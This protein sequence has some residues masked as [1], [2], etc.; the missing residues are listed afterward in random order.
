MDWMRRTF[1][2][3]LHDGCE[4]GASP[5]KV[6]GQRRETA[7]KRRL[8]VAA[9]LGF[10]ALVAA[11][12]QAASPPPTPP[13]DPL[14]TAVGNEMVQ[15]LT[16]SPSY[17]RTGLVAAVTAPLFGCSQNHAESCIHL[18]VSRDG[19]ASWHRAAAQNWTQSR[20][21]IATDSHGHDVMYSFGSAGLTRSDDAGQT[22][23]DVSNAGMPT[24]LPSYSSDGG[25]VIASTTSGKQD[26][27]LRNGSA[28]PV[29]GS[30]SNTVDFNYMAS[31]EFPA[32]GSFNPALLLGVNPQT[33]QPLILHCNAQFSC[34]TPTPL[35]W[36]ADKQ[37]LLSLQS[38][39]YPSS[40]YAEHGS[41]FVDT[42]FGIQKSLDGGLTFTTLPVAVGSGA[43]QTTTPMMALAPGYREAGPNRTV[44]AAVFQ[45]FMTQKGGHAAG[46]IYRS[47]DGGSS[48]S[49]LA[50]HGPFAG[51]AQAV[52]VAS[53][54]RLFAGYYDATDHAGLL[55]SID[56]G[57]T[58]RASCPSVVSTSGQKSGGVSAAGSGCKACP[59]GPAA[60]GAGSADSGSVGGGQS[61]ATTGSSQLPVGAASAHQGRSVVPWILIGVAVTLALLALAWRFIGTGR[62]RQRGKSLP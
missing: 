26:Y 45:A 36:P 57:A 37:G 52:A 53:D 34:D 58:W 1:D 12:A 8:V 49:A 43:T 47:T 30:S 62:R 42:T 33:Y 59:S 31:P 40:D 9:L 32:G 16:V 3:A 35:P 2:L 4:R 11:P 56:G 15:W 7:R 6:S 44:Y 14:P 55:C 48:W 24:I 27:L 51:G 38:S 18:W 20:P 13:P 25:M 46:G 22:W 5:R 29:A 28:T 19:G 60:A 39:I 17:Q 21:V 41:V 61:G 50:S 54:G 23:V 10:G